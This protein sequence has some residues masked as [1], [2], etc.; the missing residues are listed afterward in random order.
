MWPAWATVGRQSSR[1]VCYLG[2]FFM[3]QS[4]RGFL[5]GAGSLLT[6]AFVAD[7]RSFVRRTSRPLLASS[8]QV[9]Q[10]LHLYDCDDDGYLRTLGPW[11]N[12]SAPGA[13]VARVLHQRGYSTPDRGGGGKDLGPLRFRAGGLRQDRQRGLLVGS[14]RDAGRSLGGSL[15]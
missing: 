8:T 3:L 13:D 9:T 6:A 2:G 15:P 12:G 1:C 14:V 5:I 10:T 7:A 4:R 11:T